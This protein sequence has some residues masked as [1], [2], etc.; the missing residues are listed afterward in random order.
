MSIN[1]DLDIKRILYG[2]CNH[3]LPKDEWT[4]EAHFASAIAILSERGV[5]AFKDMPQII[6]AYNKATGVQ[7]TDNEGYHHTITMASL[8]A[9]RVFIVEGSPSLLNALHKLLT[10]KYGQ[11]DWPLSY[12][13]K[14][15]LFSVK[16]RKFWVEPN[17][18][19]LPFR[20]DNLGA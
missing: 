12:W 10:S 9:T 18:K 11:S 4:H 13:S 16:A 20:T 8:C 7:N 15:V 19:K 17:L 2:I 6:R 1:S 3:T 5:D 14:D